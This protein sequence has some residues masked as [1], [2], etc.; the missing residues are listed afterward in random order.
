MVFVQKLA[1]DLGFM[2]FLHTPKLVSFNA[3]NTPGKYML[4]RDKSRRARYRI[5]CPDCSVPS[6]LLYFERYLSQEE[7]RKKSSNIYRNRQMRHKSAVDTRAA[8]KPEYKFGQKVLLSQHLQRG[9]I[10]RRARE[11]S[12]LQR[13]EKLPVALLRKP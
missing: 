13:V 11:M 5:A 6:P 1:V 8:T 2:I 10:D 12:T 7:K 3:Y 9:T 4:L